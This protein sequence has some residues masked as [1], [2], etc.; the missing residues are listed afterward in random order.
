MEPIIFIFISFLLFTAS[1]I[2]LAVGQFKTNKEIESVENRIKTI[3]KILNIK[4]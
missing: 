3:H 4:D 1:L 2:I